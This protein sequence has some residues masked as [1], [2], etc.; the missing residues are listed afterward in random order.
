A[1]AYAPVQEAGQATDA[2]FDEY[3]GVHEGRRTIAA[4]HH[5]DRGPLP[6]AASASSASC[7]VAAIAS[8]QRLP[9]PAATARQ[10]L[11]LGELPPAS[12]LIESLF[13][14]PRLS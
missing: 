7:G 1:R 14:P 4:G 6:D 5:H 11:H 2:T 10:L 12:L 8:E 9:S 13:R 3:A